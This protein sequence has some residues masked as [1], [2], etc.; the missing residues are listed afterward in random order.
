M[1]LLLY[2]THTECLGTKNVTYG[3]GGGEALCAVKNKWIKTGSIISMLIYCIQLIGSRTKNKTL[4][5][6]FINIHQPEICVISGN[7][8]GYIQ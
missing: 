7:V 8:M 3:G 5:F 4:I 1:S 6:Y 2:H